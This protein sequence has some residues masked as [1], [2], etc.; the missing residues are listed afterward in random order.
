MESD[1]NKEMDARLAEG[2]KDLAGLHQRLAE[3][4]SD[5]IAEAAQTHYTQ[6]MP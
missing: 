4:I 1:H 6:P 3:I 2:Y 5:A